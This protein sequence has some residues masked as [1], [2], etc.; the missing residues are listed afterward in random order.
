MISV[1]GTGVVVVC[2]CCVSERERV[3][4]CHNG[5]L[6][7][8]RE[9]QAAGGKGGWGWGGDWRTGWSWGRATW[10]IRACHVSR[11]LL[12]WTVWSSHTVQR[13][14]QLTLQ[15]CDCGGWAVGSYA[16]EPIS[17]AYKMEHVLSYKKK[18]FIFQLSSKTI[19][20]L[21]EVKKLV[22]CIWQTKHQIYHGATVSFC[23]GINKAN[24]HFNEAGILMCQTPIIVS[25]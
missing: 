14:S 10:R 9:S 15:E 7:L 16:D 4:V 24:R 3:C 20:C 25:Y 11:P 8:L 6:T 2:M 21:A 22:C 5:L 23:T 18:Q 12:L 19:S 13:L 17:S 1:R